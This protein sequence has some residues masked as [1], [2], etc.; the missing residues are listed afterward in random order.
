[1]HRWLLFE[2]GRVQPTV[3]ALRLRLLTGRIEERTPQFERLARSAYDVLTIMDK[4]LEGRRYVA[5]S[6]F[7]IADIALYGYLHVAFEA[8]LDI[9]QLGHFNR[10]LQRVRD[11]PGHIAD[12]EPIPENEWTPAD[13]AG[14]LTSKGS[15][16]PVAR[17]A[18]TG[19]APPRSQLAQ[20]DPDIDDLGSE[21]RE[22]RHRAPG[23]ARAGA[24]HERA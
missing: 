7:S 14:Q 23:R 1:M 5:T 18:P 21:R 24:H 4:H 16:R 6:A 8:G 2:V 19:H 13:S 22:D 10:W 20:T 15:Q 9:S 12:L 11:E 17:A 3:A